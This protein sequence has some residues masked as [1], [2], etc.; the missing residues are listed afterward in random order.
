MGAG[1]RIL[2]KDLQ[3]DSGFRHGDLITMRFHRAPKRDE[4]WRFGLGMAAEISIGSPGTVVPQFG[5]ILQ[6]PT[7]RMGGEKT[8]IHGHH[9]HDGGS[10]RLD[11]SRTTWP[12]V[13]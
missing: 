7:R 9:S 3:I 4:I 2:L 12:D 1:Q 11:L 6:N 8:T 10:R 5:E 13:G